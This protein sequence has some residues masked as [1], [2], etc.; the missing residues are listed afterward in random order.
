MPVTR[1]VGRQAASAVATG[2]PATTTDTTSATGT[3]T[4][5]TQTSV[6]EITEGSSQPTVAGVAVEEQQ[7]ATAKPPQ[8]PTGSKPASTTKRSSKA[9]RVAQAKTE[10]ARLRLELAAAKLAEIA[11]ADS[12]E[13]DVDS[14]ISVAEAE[15]SRR[16]DSWLRE[17][18]HQPPPEENVPATAAVSWRASAP[19]PAGV[20]AAHP[21]SQRPGATQPL[22][23]TAAVSRQPATAAPA[24]VPA[25]A[26]ASWQPAAAAQAFEP[27]TAAAPWQQLQPTIAAAP[28]QP[29]NYF[30][31][32]PP[33]I[34]A[35]HNSKEVSRQF[36][37]NTDVSK[38]NVSCVKEPAVNSAN[39]QQGAVKTELQELAS[40]ITQAVQAANYKQPL[41][42]VELPIFN[43]AHQEWLTF[44]AAYCETS[45]HFTEVENM[46]R[47]R[48]SLRGIAKDAVQGLLITNA[49]PAGV[50]KTLET[51][52]GRPE[53][54]AMAEMDR[55]RAL[56][57]LTE[58]PRDLCT[59][60]T[61]IQNI[62][63]TLQALNCTFY[64]YNPEL[65]KGLTEKL[66][67][68]LKRQWY[69]YAASQLAGLPDLV[70]FNNFV[71]REAEF[72]SPFAA[73]E[74]IVDRTPSKNSD[75]MQRRQQRVHAATERT[76]EAM[77]SLC[78]RQGHTIADCT[79]FANADV[80]T[81]WDE[82]KKR[83]LCFRCLRRRNKQHRCKSKQCDID[84]CE[85]YHHRMLHSTHKPVESKSEEQHNN[86]QV[87]S[88]W[89]PRVSFLKIAPVRIFGPRKAVDTFALL[90]DG[91]TVSLVDDDLAKS[92]GIDGPEEPLHI[93]TYDGT[94][95]NN[96]GSRR[97]SFKIRG[98][99]ENLRTQQIDAHT[100]NDLKL[101]TQKISREAVRDCRHLDEFVAH[102][103]PREVRPRIL[104][105]QDNWHLLLATRT[106]KGK[107][108][109]PVASLTPLGWVV[110]GSRSRALEN[111]VNFINY[112][113]AA[114]EHMQKLVE[115]YI[116]TDNMY[117][118]PKMPQ[119]TM[120]EKALKILEGKT[121]R[122]PDGRYQT[123]LLWKSEEVN[124]PCNYQNTLKRL[125]NV[126]RKLDKDPQLRC[127][128]S[129]QMEAL[130]RKGY[131]EPAVPTTS[132]KKWY[133]PHFA[134][135][136]AKKPDKLRVV[137][138][139]AAKT[140]G[141]SLN[142][143]LY[144]GPDLLQ[145]LPGIL[146]R[147]R[148]HPFAITADISEMFLQIQL[149]EEDRDALR[150]LWR[151]TRRDDKPP[152][153]YRMK[154]LI[155]GA[156][157]SPSTA[158]FV[159]NLNA[160]RFK[161]ECPEAVAA[162]RSKHYMDDYI[163]SFET[164]E[165]AKEIAKQV[166]RIHSEAHFELKKWASNS[167]ELL[168]ALG[169]KSSSETVN[170][171]DKHER[172]LGLIWRPK[173]DQLAFDLRLVDVPPSLLQDEVPTK[174]QALKIVMSVF[175]PLGLLSPLT[176]KPKQLLQEV[177]RRGTP[178]DDRL[179]A[180]IAASWS[181]WLTQLKAASNIAVPRCYLSY[182]TAS[183][184]EL[185]VF[186]DASES[187]YAAVLYWRTVDSDGTTAVTLLTAK[188]KVAP[189]KLL[190]IPRMELQAA[191][192]GTRMAIAV[193][194]EHQHKPD[195]TT[196]WTDSRTTLCWIRTGARAFKPYVA[197]RIAA[198][199]EGS[200][201]PEWRWVP[202]KWNVADDAT[203][204]TPADFG[205]E[206]RW[207]HG[208]DFLRE[209]P[210]AWPIEKD[211]QPA[212]TTGEERS[213]AVF[214]IAQKQHLSD[215]IPDVQRFSSWLRYLRATARVL[216][217][218]QILRQRT[219][220]IHYKRTKKRPSQ[221]PDWKNNKASDAK[222]PKPAVSKRSDF[223]ILPAELQHRAETLIIRASQE[224][225]FEA[226]L[227]ALTNGTQ[228]PRDSRLYPLS[229]HI[230]EGIIRLKSRI[231]AAIGVSENMKNPPIVD[232]GHLATKLWIKHIHELLHHAGTEST[233]NQC[234]QYRWVI[235]LRPTVK[236][237]ISRCLKCRMK[238]VN[239]PQPI[240]GDLPPC[241]LA[242]H[243]RPF[244]YTGL[245]YF[246]PLTITVGRAHQKRY[247][248][249][250][251]C[252]TVRAVHLEIV[253]SLSTDSAIMALRRMIA[254]R[255]CPAEIWSDNATNFHGAEKELRHM[256]QDG[257]ERE[258]SRRAIRWRFIPPGAPFM[259]GAW[260][261]LVRS[262]K[263][264]LTVVLREK[265]PREETLSTLLAE[266]ENTVNSRPLTHVS[267]S[268]EDPEAL[269]PNHFL[270]GCQGPI[271]TPGFSEDYGYGSNI[272]LRAA[273]QLAN[274]FWARWLREYLPELRNRREPH[275]RGPT[276]HT[277]DLVRIVD[278]NLPRN[279]WV[280]GKIIATHP[281]PDGIV[282]TVDIAT[283]GGVLR[284]P[285]KKVIVILPAC[286]TA[287]C[288]R[289]GDV[290][291]PAGDTRREDVQDD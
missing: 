56:P 127:R 23:A 204:G 159:M 220:R 170:I 132:M 66:T 133:L 115:E 34:A 21:P 183:R 282:R 107:R 222:Q 200:R 40:A 274:E 280:R 259:G 168:K 10:L 237:I 245:D 114:D 63:G 275:G 201:V 11:A 148:E 189:L 206:H 105:G 108:N 249:L 254:R 104:I 171:Q 229:T 72:C 52:F 71:M 177:W 210:E 81:R 42:Y 125:H 44:R 203:R 271:V 262:V 247:V 136:N 228:L 197:H 194:N 62:V 226:E 121:T 269:T 126:E 57:R 49:D 28:W 55:L 255:G 93:C 118:Q 240:T 213:H 59:F 122:M 130:I 134:V 248:T 212:H 285:T 70:K 276:L 3:T 286:E 145:P 74:T 33:V 124:M 284:R 283:R 6:T 256:L 153:E 234:R 184:L 167:P 166:R 86:E 17:S 101:A 150:Y 142:D 279:A 169:E 111:R 41:R 78:A 266:V 192:L 264:A 190:S 287:T 87:N 110:H 207:F 38:P 182:S 116:T 97:V 221:D 9:H 135:I 12:D 273:Q 291:P 75:G 73:A 173:E 281:G 119:N 158:I 156:S 163:D 53:S 211:P 175:D 24:F 139:A 217:A 37:A 80:N 180:D 4:E 227:R 77:C 129:E 179:D 106:K 205:A 176:I 225:A 39:T 89:V 82:A 48:R 88:A 224:E 149:R 123:G 131:A 58:S 261:R 61:R 143:Y 185:H 152:Q 128:Y 32:A 195:S 102:L 165:K 47:L 267:V 29:R 14:V 83:N 246:G 258:A 91:S 231:T 278:G 144:T 85:R 31:Q 137:H 92:I 202:T 50:M 233:V 8:P 239:P 193:K 288:T 181:R 94:T 263:T 65:T 155:F 120:E 109:Q 13:D 98:Q 238:M 16:V 25:T 147:F 157:S 117:I 188:A 270:L 99:G 236:E 79:R 146:M 95:R 69:E 76:D 46:S 187:A 35:W 252:L 290:S 19:T 26:A 84:G 7:A 113:A 112:T 22:P 178:W 64:M 30:A 67:P 243:Q 216:K 250:F 257:A 244:T 60:A 5:A 251:T 96:A 2:T 235:R 141:V 232:G 20:T 289:Q 272:N 154:T 45:H 268:P 90:D 265:H 174:R 218:I 196:F 260:E 54:I 230:S 36:P 219:Q 51:R 186:T 198:I 27:V 208:P 223:V 209:K 242:H 164:L 100:V 18:Q 214:A 68:T 253:H 241:R 151:G 191:V 140:R 162:I 277:G 215:A 161:E 103:D 160:E 199:E 43:G 1:S 172:V 15:Q 138:D